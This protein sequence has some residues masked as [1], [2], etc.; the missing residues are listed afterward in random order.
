MFLQ[1]HGRITA[2]RTTAEGPAYTTLL[3][4]A[5]HSSAQAPTKWHGAD[6]GAPLGVPHSLSTEHRRVRRISHASG[7]QIL[8]KAAS[9]PF[10]PA[11][12]SESTQPSDYPSP[13]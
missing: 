9:Q 7:A 13:P 5:F 3:I 8:A 10:R 12:F 1:S 4:D 11:H 2:Q 6:P